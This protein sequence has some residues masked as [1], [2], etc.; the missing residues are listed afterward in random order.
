M[1]PAQREAPSASPSRALS[2]SRV[3]QGSAM[4]GRLPGWDEGAI[5]Q[6]SREC[7]EDIRLPGLVTELGSRSLSATS[8]LHF[9]PMVFSIMEHIKN[10]EVKS[11]R[12]MK[13]LK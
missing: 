4:R 12:I 2:P 8:V 1:E 6:A 5:L 10:S 7:R 11:P 9:V 3:L 13:N